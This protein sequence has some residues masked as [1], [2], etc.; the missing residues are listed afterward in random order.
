MYRLLKPAGVFLLHGIADLPGRPVKT[1]KGFIP[2]SVFP[3][4]ELPSMTKR[5]TAAEAH[6]FE[7][8]DVESLRENYAQTLRHWA[9]RR[10]AG[11]ALNRFEWHQ[12]ATMAA[13]AAMPRVEG[14]A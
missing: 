8:R 14:R 7:T 1:T 11:V 5:M 6:D 13:M 12:E 3:D 10:R 2:T 9:R 4:S